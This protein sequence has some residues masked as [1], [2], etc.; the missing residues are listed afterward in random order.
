MLTVNLILLY[1]GYVVM[2]GP[3]I[4]SQ[5]FILYAYTRVLSKCANS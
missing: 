4:V 5:T 1:K 3:I 2:F